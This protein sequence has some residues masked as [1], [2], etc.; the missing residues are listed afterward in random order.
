MRKSKERWQRKRHC[1]HVINANCTA[2]VGP[3]GAH[4]NRTWTQRFLSFSIAYYICVNPLRINYYGLV[5]ELTFKVNF[6]FPLL[7]YVNNRCTCSF[8]NSQMQLHDGLWYFIFANDF[9]TSSY[10]RYLLLFKKIVEYM[11]YCKR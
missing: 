7:F 5:E 10:Y 2:R 8:F 9:V 4:Q 6:F 11:K 1:P 3:F